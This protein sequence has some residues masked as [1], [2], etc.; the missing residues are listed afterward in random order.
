MHAHRRAVLRRSRQYT[1]GNKA[2]A[3]ALDERRIAHR[4]CR[5]R[6][7]RRCALRRP[8]EARQR[9]GADGYVPHRHSRYHAPQLLSAPSMIHCWIKAL[10]AALIVNIESAGGIWSDGE[11]ADSLHMFTPFSLFMM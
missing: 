2:F 3:H 10:S 7:I 9:C 4:H 11:L 1:I 8:D 6:T 5:R